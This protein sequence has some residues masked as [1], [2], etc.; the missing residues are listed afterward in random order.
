MSTKN[1]TIPIQAIHTSHQQQRLILQ[2]L[3]G[4][5]DLRLATLPPL[6]LYVHIPW[7]I[8]KCPYCDF[9]S[10]EITPTHLTPDG[11]DEAGYLAAL[12]KDIE[13]SLPMIWGRKIHS[14]F[15][16]GGTPSLLSAK[17]LDQLLADIRMLLPLEAGIEITLEANPGTFEYAKFAEYARSGITR[18]SIGVQSF[19]PQHLQALGR[20]HDREQ[21]LRAIEIAQHCFSTFNIDLMFALPTQTLAQQAEDLRTALSFQP[22]HLSY[23]HLTL[24]PNTYFAKYPPPLPDDDTAADMQDAIAEQL[25]AAGYDHYEVSAYAQPDHHAQHNLNYWLFGDYLGIGAGAHSKISL[26]HR[27]MRLM[28]HK[29][30]KAYLQAVQ[31]ATPEDLAHIQS[32]SSVSASDLPFE[33]MLNALRLREGFPLHYYSER[34]G[35]SLNALDAVLESAANQGLLIQSHERIAPSPRG[36]QYLNDLQ[37]LFLG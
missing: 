19:N 8:R 36:W 3:F 32:Q 11:F 10:H 1:I 24:E 18:L 17:G 25:S 15:I 28:R 29:Q 21:A 35:L 33:F 26:P 20:V 30:P 6:S 2:D 12:R 9:N 14:I 22:P 5:G 27:I 13:L 7:C 16:G 4:A 23:Y 34:T 31:T 37:R